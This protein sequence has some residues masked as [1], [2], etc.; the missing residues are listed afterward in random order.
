MASPARS[1]YK[2]AATPSTDADREGDATTTETDYTTETA[3][4]HQTT[5]QEY[6][7]HHRI[8]DH[9]QTS[10]S[11][12][13][14]T[15][16]E[17]SQKR[18]SSTSA[19][20]LDPVLLIPLWRR[21]PDTRE[22]RPPGRSQQQVS[23]TRRSNNQ[24]T[25]NPRRRWDEHRPASLLFTPNLEEGLQSELTR[26]RYEIKSSNFSADRQNSATY[27]LDYYSRTRSGTR[28]GPR[29]V[30]GRARGRGD[31]VMNYN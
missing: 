28:P 22:I 1:S 27:R 15:A 23:W 16:S 12:S 24:G 9:H 11:V 7:Y 5:L 17:E 13:R 10:T 2:T 26:I 4:D 31:L 25:K 8:A 30:S 29:T 18:V 14:D 20:S 3:S 19:R 6:S 21:V